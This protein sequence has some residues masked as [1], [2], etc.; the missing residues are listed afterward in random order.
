VLAA[1]TFEP[2]LAEFR[3]TATNL[4]AFIESERAVRILKSEVGL[5]SRIIERVNSLPNLSPAARSLAL[6]MSKVL[7]ENPHDLNLASWATVS[8]P[9]R[10]QAAYELAWRKPKPPIVSN[11]TL[12][13]SIPGRRPISR[14]P[15]Q[16]SHRDL[17]LSRKANSNGPDTPADLAFLA[18][19]QYRAGQVDVSRRQLNKL[20]DAVKAATGDDERA[21]S[22]RSRATDRCVETKLTTPTAPVFRAIG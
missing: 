8:K 5:K 4:L 11:L 21:L 6:L 16:A 3:S 19:A 22:W 14:G 9:G 12:K 20:R 18:M 17:E 1:L 2:S 10:D 15:V 13:S 7:E